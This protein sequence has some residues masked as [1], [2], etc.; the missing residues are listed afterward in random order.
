MAWSPATVTDGCVELEAPFVPKAVSAAAS[1]AGAEGA[2]AAR[3]ASIPPAGPQGL[4][5]C[6]VSFALAKLTRAKHA[7]AKLTQQGN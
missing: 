5:P 2:A 1:G 4:L 3:S 7:R 6:W